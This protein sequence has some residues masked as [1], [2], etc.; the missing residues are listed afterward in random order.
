MTRLAEI[1]RR[2]RTRHEAWEYLASR[3]FSC[4]L[5]ASWVNGRWAARVRC[6]DDGV[7]VTVWLRQYAA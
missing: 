4:R 5:D 7:A 1:H 3:G 2:Y 6:A